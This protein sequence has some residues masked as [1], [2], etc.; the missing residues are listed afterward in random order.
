MASGLWE[1]RRVR[2]AGSRP[3]INLSCVTPLSAPAA[4][5]LNAMVESGGPRAPC[6]P[7]PKV[8]PGSQEP[9]P[10]E[11]AMRYGEADRQSDQVEDR[12][13]RGG[14]MFPGGGGEI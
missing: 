14:G 3:R 12:R 6:A 7:A 5:A 1:Q 2:A 4:R 8:Q 11:A 13:G 10:E 9:G